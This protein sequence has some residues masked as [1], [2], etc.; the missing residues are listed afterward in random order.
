VRSHDNEN[1]LAVSTPK[2][3][4]DF[5]KWWSWHIQLCRNCK[6][7][8]W[9]LDRPHK[10]IRFTDQELLRDRRVTRQPLG[11]ENGVVSGFAV[12]WPENRAFGELRARPFGHEIGIV[13]LF[14]IFLDRIYY[15]QMH[16]LE[17]NRAVTP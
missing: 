17:H 6:L 3:V 9:F 7:T 12:H 10:S 5:R 1:N 16:R 11:H 2:S 4:A 15:F 8:P 14:F 13:Q